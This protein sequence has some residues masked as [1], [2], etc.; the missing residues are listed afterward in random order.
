M[1]HLEDLGGPHQAQSLSLQVC[2]DAPLCPAW[3][4]SHKQAAPAPSRLLPVEPLNIQPQSALPV[5]EEGV[6]SPSAS[7]PALLRSA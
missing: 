3:P 5:P 1:T 4:Q 6:G 2:G 7:L